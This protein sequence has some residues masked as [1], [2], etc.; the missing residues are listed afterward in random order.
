[1]K[2]FGSFF[3]F[4]LKR[5]FG[6]RNV[7]VLLLFFFVSMYLV[8]LGVK[9]YNEVLK[10]KEEFQ[11]IEKKKVEE[12]VNYTQYGGYGFRL[13][14]LPPP[15]SIFFY[16]SSLFPELNA[17][18]DVGGKLTIYNSFQGK[19]VFSESQGKFL[20]FSGFMLL[21]GSLMTL[22]YGY[23]FLRHRD[24]QKFL[25]SLFGWKR[26]F[27][28]HI[29]SNII[30]LSLFFLAAAVVPLIVQNLVGKHIA[31]I[32]FQHLSG[33]FVATVLLL[34]FFFLIGT[35]IGIT[36]SKFSRFLIILV[37]VGSVYF[38]PALFNYV[39]K[40]TSKEL[41][42]NYQYELKKLNALMDFERRA[43]EE[44]KKER[45]KSKTETIDLEASIRTIMRSYKD[46][47]FETIEEHDG[48]AEKEIAPIIRR[49]QTFSIFFP[50]AFY[51]SV[52]NEIS[53][54]GY[55]NVLNF[56]HHARNIRRRFVE[57]YT[58]KKA[59]E[60]IKIRLKRERPPTV[61]SF[62]GETDQ[63]IFK[64][65]SNLPI[66][67]GWGVLITLLWIAVLTALSYWSYKKALFSLPERR[68]DDLGE[69]EIEINRE[70]SHA[71]LSGDDVICQLLYTILSGM[72][73]A[74]RW[75]KRFNGKVLYN[76]LNIV[77]KSQK[78]EFVYICH[79]GQVP[80][81]I[82]ARNFV[83]LIGRS[84]KLSRKELKELGE[85][86]NLKQVGKKYFSDL[87]DIEKARIIFS[88]ALLKKCGIYMIHDF[89]KGMPAHFTDEIIAHV[90][91]LKQRGAAVVYLTSDA[92][93]AR[94][95][96]DYMT[97]MKK[98]AV[99]MGV[100]L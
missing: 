4:E 41:T 27:F 96:G 42:S 15:L 72:S 79:P 56:F 31:E 73:G 48:A 92:S 69:L 33:F 24:H 77:E 78:T 17:H 50:T 9:Q 44:F 58:D 81:I 28:C 93:L 70:E 63:N 30:L 39:V 52:N 91:N 100:K 97:L 53:G 34:I 18:I 47:E 6:W 87:S 11:E 80:W 5:F 76:D 46:Y 29:G 2:T 49:A 57:F 82:K 19:K 74:Y 7:I 43:E 68:I 12:F 66:N 21:F 36:H 10:S 45:E 89:T 13:Y 85:K 35:I 25:A 90:E 55:Q 8:H 37:W 84:F 98:D 23:D 99:S 14:F 22:F 40:V 94:K 86:L 83:Y 95:V 26:S 32:K 67:F 54:K 60:I 61:E 1:M 62:I 75:S 20:D 71:I 16:N 88:C 51:L 64:A 3:A 65:K 59:E 38:V